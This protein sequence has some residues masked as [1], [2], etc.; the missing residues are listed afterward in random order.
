MAVEQAYRC[1]LCGELVHKDALSRLRAGQLDWRPEDFTPVDV[2]PGCC[3]KPV[4]DVLAK[5][6][7]RNEAE[8]V[9]R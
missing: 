7:E 1:D 8:G 2:C 5:A 3:A 6:A 4:T 9:F